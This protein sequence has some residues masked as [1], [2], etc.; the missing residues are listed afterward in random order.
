MKIIFLLFVINAF[1]SAQID[2][3]DFFLNKTLRIDYYHTGNKENDSYSMDELIEEPYWGGS[4]KNLIDK[5][6]Y[7]NYKFEAYDQTSNKL[8]YSRTYST[9]FRE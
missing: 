1:A 5:F 9:L 6:N 3:D 4:K 8:I 7:G 2:F